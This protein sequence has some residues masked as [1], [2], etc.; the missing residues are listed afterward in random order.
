MFLRSSEF[1]AQRGIISNR[2]MNYMMLNK[3]QANFYKGDGQIQSSQRLKGNHTIMSPYGYE[4]GEILIDDLNIIRFEDNELIFSVLI[5][6]DNRGSMRLLGR[7]AEALMVR[8]CAEDIETNKRW[9]RKGMMSAINKRTAEKFH[10]V[11]TG[12]A[13]TKKNHPH[14]YNP[15]DSQRDIIWIDNK[16]NQAMMPSARD[17]NSG[18]PAGLQL[19]VSTNGIGYIL[20]DLNTYRYEVPLVYFGLEDD[21]DN[22][23]SIKRKQ[24]DNFIIRPG[25]HFINAKSEDPSIY[26]ALKYYQPI[27]HDL[28][29]G[30]IKLEDIIYL[31]RNDF[32]LKNAVATKAL[33]N[34]NMRTF[35][36]L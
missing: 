3:F 8:R 6:E 28:C 26:D 16:G 7:M 9:L 31:T 22:I 24:E 5:T 20:H 30:K 19:K 1:Y 34:M 36:T 32:A 21:F 35:I 10:A 15:S 11:G 33:N 13:S 2:G 14:K 23:V 25:E 18:I 17:W 27:I 29:A 4:L 12:L